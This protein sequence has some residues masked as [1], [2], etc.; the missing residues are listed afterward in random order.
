MEWNTVER[1]EKQPQEQNKRSGRARLVYDS[2]VTGLVCEIR[3]VRVSEATMLW[4]V[5]EWVWAC[6]NHWTTTVAVSL[7]W[8]VDEAGLMGPRKGRQH[9]GRH[10]KC[11]S[12]LGKEDEGEGEKG[13]PPVLQATELE[14]CCGIGLP[15]KK[16]K[17][18]MEPPFLPLLPPP[19]PKHVSSCFVV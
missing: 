19:P 13:F 17:K 4:R 1:R 3:K 6:A 2:A 11:F 7:Y 5:Q 10:P 16:K 14:T 12:A 8:S 15:Y 9:H 18:N